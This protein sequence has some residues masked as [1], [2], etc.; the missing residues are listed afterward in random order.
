M[1]KRIDQVTKTYPLK[2]KNSRKN[3]N[4]ILICSSNK[5]VAIKVINDKAMD[6]LPTNSTTHFYQSF[7][8]CTTLPTRYFREKL[9]N[10]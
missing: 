6:Y 10:T 1:L 7:L 5:Y 2:E 3:C 4:D 8:R 9:K